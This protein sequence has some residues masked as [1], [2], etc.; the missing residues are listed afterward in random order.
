M[1]SEKD[2]KIYNMKLFAES[3]YCKT[4][5]FL[6]Y[7]QKGE[8]YRCPKD[9]VKYEDGYGPF[10]THTCSAHPAIPNKYVPLD[11][12]LKEPHH[13]ILDTFEIEPGRIAKQKLEIKMSE[14]FKTSTAEDIAIRIYNEKIGQRHLDLLDAKEKQKQREK[15][16]EK[17][18]AEMERVKKDFVN[19]LTSAVN[20][21]KQAE[22]GVEK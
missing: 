1:N 6:Q 17:K 5:K 3:E 4:C 19:Y 15:T 18:I 21:E 22:N 2:Y 20:F 8:E 14:L 10:Y 7:D 13:F 12:D 9:E 16:I 11:K